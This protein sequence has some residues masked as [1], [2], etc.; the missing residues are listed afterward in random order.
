MHHLI[1]VSDNLQILV[2]RGTPEPDHPL[3]PIGNTV[4]QSPRRGESGKHEVCVASPT[5]TQLCVISYEEAGIPAAC[6][7]S[8]STSVFFL[9]FLKGDFFGSFAS[10]LLPVLDDVY[11]MLLPIIVSEK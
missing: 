10:V 8:L 7:P 1:Y 5:C 2:S 9:S 3:L 6:L 11:P 4:I